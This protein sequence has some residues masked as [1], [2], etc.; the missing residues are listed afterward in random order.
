MQVIPKNKNKIFLAGDIGGTKTTLGLFSI[1]TGPHAPITEQIYAS[2]EHPNLS[3]IIDQFL[4][5]HD[6]KPT[7]ACFG[8]AGPVLSGTVKVTNLPWEISAQQL[9]TQHGF[10]R[11]ELLNDLQAIA[12]ST[13]HLRPEDLFNIHPGTTTTGGTI[14]IIAP[15]TGLGEAFMAWNNTEYLPLAS[16]GGHV[17][18]APTT[19]IQAELLKFLRKKF[20]HVSYERVCSGS[21]IPNLYDFFQ[22]RSNQTNP[23]KI[24]KQIAAAKDP[25]PTILEAAMKGSCS[26]CQD[27]LNLFIEILGSE[28]G[29]L[30]LKV[31]SS[32]GIF[33]GGGIPPRILSA[34]D[35]DNFRRPFLNKG[36]LSYL[37]EAM[38]VH[39]I[40]NSRAA[41]IGAASHCLS[42]I[43]TRVA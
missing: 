18:F 10:S 6:L 9:L 37:L 19:K 34:L 14:G 35:S 13:P 33:L 1:E 32:G 42:K 7:M 29:N 3:V 23:S 16:E 2:S 40:T 22:S 38:P 31:M 43:K 39:V 41:M 36:R 24:S 21:G 8:V 20:N 28:T 17:D 25:A 27:T 12:A 26:V 4:S 30:A 15:G 5:S 11:V